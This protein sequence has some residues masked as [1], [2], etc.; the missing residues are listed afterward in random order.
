MLIGDKTVIRAIELDDINLLLKW[1]EDPEISFLLGREFP[2]STEMQ[3]KWYERTLNNSSKRKFIVETKDK[4]SIGMLGIMDIDLKNRHCECGITIGEKN[5][6]G[7]GFASDALSVI[8][9][10]LFEELGMNRIYAKIYEYNQK[11]LK[12]FN[13]LGF[14]ID[15]EI[16]DF[17]YT[18]GK[19]YNMFILSLKKG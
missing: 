7:Q 19:Y 14:Q 5:Y 12:L 3:K 17:I 10:Y 8:I 13:S 2:L 15:G 4:I 18:D 1:R 9:K 16:K 11:S 6:W